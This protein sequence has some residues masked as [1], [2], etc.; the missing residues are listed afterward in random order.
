MHRLAGILASICILPSVAAAQLVTSTQHVFP[1]FVDGR[2][3]SGSG[4]RTELV[5]SNPNFV[6]A[7]C[8]LQLGG[9]TARFEAL[10]GPVPGVSATLNIGVFPAGYE[11][12]RTLAAQPLGTGYGIMNC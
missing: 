5:I 11:V 9:L 4:Y 8:S 6:F 2:I 12:I 7:N 1:W 3:G 10:N